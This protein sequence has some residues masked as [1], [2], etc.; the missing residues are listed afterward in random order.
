MN[1]QDVLEYYKAQDEAEEDFNSE[2]AQRRAIVINS[3]ARDIR[4][5]PVG[6]NKCPYCG[7]AFMIKT[8]FCGEC[9]QALK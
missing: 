7:R 1:V 3:L 9:G 5:E 8:N 2:E 6:V 4:E